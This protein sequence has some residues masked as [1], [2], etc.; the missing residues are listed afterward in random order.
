[1]RLL[2]Q[3]VMAL[4]Q[5]QYLRDVSTTPSQDL[6]N[7]KSQPS[8][9]SPAVVLWHGLGDSY[10]SDGMAAAE[11]LLK[12]KI[13]GVFVHSVYL[14]EDSARDKQASMLGDANH[15]VELVCNQLAGIPELSGGFAALG[16]SQG[17]LFLRALVEQC[18]NI[19]I[20][21]LI[22]FGSPHMGVLDLPLCDDQGD[23]T[24]R[25]RNLLL[26]Q[27]VWREHVQ[28]SVI[29]AQYFREMDHYGDYLEH[30]N[31]L[32]AINN[33]RPDS[34]ACVRKSRFEA[35]DSLVLVG[36]AKDR[37]LVPKESA[38]FQYRL[39]QTGPVLPFDETSFYTQNWLGLKT[40]HE[41]GKLHFH[42]INT[43]HMEIPEDVL[44]MLVETYLRL[45][46]VRVHAR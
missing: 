12:R 15:Q 37:T 7:L 29:P 34:S 11:E 19:S 44:E 5:S 18:P 1:M 3:F 16:F 43:A 24:C 23:W 20:S 33:E 8:Q 13:P 40:L 30:S 17:G 22:T 35:L 32:A 9:T 39:L 4:A 26:K 45:H 46:G 25:R 21:T 2:N 31:F 6:D 38:F 10:D 14:D 41:S 28:K 27:Q 36:F 42:S